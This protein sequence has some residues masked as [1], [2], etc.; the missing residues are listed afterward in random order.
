MP[1][2]LCRLLCILFQRFVDNIVNEGAD[3]DM[4]VVHHSAHELK[5]ISAMFGLAHLSQLAEGIEKCCIEGRQDEARVL[6]GK[7]QERYT[8]NLAALQ[9]VYPLQI[10]AA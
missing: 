8:T 7:I 4:S 3:G 1:D 5:S 6:A 9:E 10:E 2:S